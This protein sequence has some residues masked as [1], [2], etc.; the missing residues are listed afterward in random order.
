MPAEVSEPGSE[1]W[2]RQRTSFGDA[3]AL[4]ERVRPGYPQG[5]VDWLLPAGARRVI[6]LA[7][8]TG[9]LT[10]LL[11]ERG[12]DVVAVE[13]SAGMRAEFT[14]ALPGV[15]VLD[16]AAEALPLDDGSVDAVLVAQAWHWVDAERASRE[17][18]RVLVPGGMLGLVWN[19]RD[20]STA[21]VT[22]LERIIAE[23]GVGHGRDDLPAPEVG[24]PFGPLESTLVPWSTR[25]TPDAVVDLVASRSWAITMP[26]RR[27]E[28]MFGDIR[29]LLATHPDTAGHDLVDLPYIARCYRT[30][31]PAPS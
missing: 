5:A 26:W 31:S 30:S 4:Y 9:K 22:E 14:R 18:A 16:G 23:P 2:E 15:P 25:L 17:I 20:P 7:A 29:H 1:G 8:G 12:L 3:A 19:L 13:P 28:A 27:R 6:D 10:R 21:W 11:V 24:P